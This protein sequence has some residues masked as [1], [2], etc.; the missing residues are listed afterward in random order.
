MDL[1]DQPQAKFVLGSNLKLMEQ[2]TL[3]LSNHQLWLTTLQFP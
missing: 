2:V 1:Q 3:S